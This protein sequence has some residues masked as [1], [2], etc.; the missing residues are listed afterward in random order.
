MNRIIFILVLWMGISASF[1]FA[2]SNDTL[3]SAI[4]SNHLVVNDTNVAN[5]DLIDSSLA[6]TPVVDLPI[7]EDLRQDG[8]PVSYTSNTIIFYSLLAILL[9]LGMI[10]Y[11]NSLFYKNIF[12]SFISTN[13]SF[14]HVKTQMGQQ[15]LFNTLMNALFFII[16]GIYIYYIIQVFAPSV[17]LL[18]TRPFINISIFSVS[19]LLIYGFKI[20]FLQLL[21]Y[22]FSI[23]E[24]TNEYTFNILL[25]NKI[26]A[27]ILLPF[28]CFMIFGGPAVAKIT[29]ILSFLVIG[30]AMLNRYAR[31][32]ESMGRILKV[33]KFH[34]FIYLC[35]SEFLPFA[36]IGKYILESA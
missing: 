7:E 27:V 19:L 16:A 22:L 6:V 31:S 4:D 13:N 14:R 30:L 35:A 29:T 34:F 33:N 17:P 2:Q 32:R 24:Y 26:L 5:P 12:K 20:A 25:I 9:L 8:H 18:S 36:I 23:D 21:G 15:T 11:S 1:C 28:L 10:R 3:G